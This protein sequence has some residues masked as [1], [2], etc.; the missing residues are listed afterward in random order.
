MKKRMTGLGSAA[1]TVT[2]REGGEK[3]D[4]LQEGF[5]KTKGSSYVNFGML[6]PRGRYRYIGRKTPHLHVN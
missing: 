6:C 2:A 3:S 4:F 1:A 5:P